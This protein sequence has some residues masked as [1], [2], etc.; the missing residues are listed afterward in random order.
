MNDPPHH[1]WIYNKLLPNRNRYIQ[2]FLNEVNRFDEFA[3]RKL[4]LQIGGKYRCPCAKCKNSMYVTP[5]F[6]H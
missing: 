1:L 5:Y 4:K 2:K 3:R 6:S